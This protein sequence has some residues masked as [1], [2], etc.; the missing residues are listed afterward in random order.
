MVTVIQNQNTDTAN[1]LLQKFMGSPALVAMYSPSL[2]RLVIHL[3]GKE[4]DLYL[5]LAGCKHMNGPFSWNNA[6]IHIS[7][8]PDDTLGHITWVSDK[9]AG[10]ELIA[11]GGF[12][13]FHGPGNEFGDSFDN[14]IDWDKANVGPNPGAATPGV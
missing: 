2:R 13:L 1:E 5:S 4:E 11:Y 8:I 6:N 3:S 9:D 10:F 7:L 14:F 12:I